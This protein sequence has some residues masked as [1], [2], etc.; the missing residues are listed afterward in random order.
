MILV[1]ILKM[2]LKMTIKFIFKL[3]TEDRKGN[4]KKKSVDC[5]FGHLSLRHNF[6]LKH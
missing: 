2:K 5:I 3:G 6:N 4:L 1:D